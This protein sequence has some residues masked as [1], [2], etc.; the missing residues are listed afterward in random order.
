MMWYDATYHCDRV[1]RVH[2]GE[3]QDV[4]LGK[5]P[6]VYIYKVYQVSDVRWFVFLFCLLPPKCFF[7]K[8]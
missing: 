6:I 3:Q 2:Y 5:V 1:D 7:F 8:K 4:V